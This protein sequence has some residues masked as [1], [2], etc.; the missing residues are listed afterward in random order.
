MITN[1]SR[2]SVSDIAMCLKDC[3]CCS[4]AAAQYLTYAEQNL[5]KAQIVLLQHQRKSLLNEL[6]QTQQKID[7]IDFI[8]RELEETI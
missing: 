6:H 8:I 3:G 5:P 7:S 1:L 4:E 2:R